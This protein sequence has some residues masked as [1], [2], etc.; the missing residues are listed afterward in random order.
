[1]PQN[2]QL[3]HR[4]PPALASRE[5]QISCLALGVICLATLLGGIL[6]FVEHSH[7]VAE[8]LLVPAGLALLTSGLVQAR[9][10]AS[11]WRT[12][13][14]TLSGLPL[15]QFGFWRALSCGAFLAYLAAL[16]IGPR[17]Y[18][19]CLWLGVVS[20]WYAGLAA[21]AGGLAL[22]VGNL[23]PLDPRP[24]G[25]QQRMAGFRRHAAAG[26]GRSEPTGAGR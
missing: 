7:A 12:G 22:D 16:A 21:A 14:L 6:C 11:A 23:A 5:Q 24:H 19:A 20:L 9:V 4:R 2:H 17:D 3:V 26:R 1:M 15:V 8:R 10:I 25:P 13:R 18:V